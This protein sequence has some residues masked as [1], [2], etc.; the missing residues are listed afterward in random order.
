MLS[1]RD[2]LRI[3]RPVDGDLW[4]VA[5]RLALKIQNVNNNFVSYSTSVNEVGDLILSPEKASWLLTQRA[6]LAVV[7]A[8]FGGYSSQIVCHRPIVTFPDL[9]NP[10]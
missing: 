10:R 3:K 8:G 1:A 2:S 7:L 9:G 5:G 6:N 4:E